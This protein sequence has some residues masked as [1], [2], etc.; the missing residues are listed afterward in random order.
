MQ[1][2]LSHPILSS[3]VRNFPLLFSTVVLLSSNCPLFL[4]ILLFINILYCPLLSCTFFYHPI[5]SSTVS[6]CPLLSSTVLF[7]LVLSHPILSSIVLT[8][9]YVLYYSCPVLLS[10]YC[11]LFFFTVLFINVLY[12]PLL[13]VTFLYSSLL[14]LYC[15]IVFKQSSTSLYCPS[16]YCTAL[17]CLLLPGDYRCKLA[18][19]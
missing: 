15:F 10:S 3:T 18:Y 19:C 8:F 5:L 16:L 4:F 12:C 14:S 9:L 13:F 2:G 17:Y 1:T 6:N 7:C 11:P